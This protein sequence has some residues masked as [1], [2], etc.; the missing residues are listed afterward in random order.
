MVA[1]NDLLPERR[2]KRMKFDLKPCLRGEKKAWDAFVE[3][4]SP[5]IYSSVKRTLSG[6]AANIPGRTL[7]DIA[8]EVF[9]RLI[10][11]DYRL[12]KQFDPERASLNTWL[13]LVARSVCIDQLRKRQIETF[14]LEDSDIKASSGNLDSATAESKNSEPIPLHLLT[15][16]Q[17]LVLS[18]LFDEQI[19]VSQAAKIIGVDDQTIRSTKHKALERLRSHFASDKNKQTGN[20]RGDGGDTT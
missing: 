3:Q 14:S 19:S 7:E 1:S 9:F 13:A 20:K 8:Q 5:M 2:K 15:A 16:R 11:D 6:S 12:L 18:M 17:K 4:F 10:R